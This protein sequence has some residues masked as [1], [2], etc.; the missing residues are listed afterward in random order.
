MTRPGSSHRDF[1]AF[2]PFRLYPSKR[3]TERSGV[4]T[5]IGGRALDI[6]V[7]LVE[8][9]GQIVSNKDLLREV[10]PTTTVG[11]ANLRMQMSAL[12]RALGSD[13]ARY[14]SNV[15]GRGYC[16]VAP[17]SWSPRTIGRLSRLLSKRGGYRCRLALIGWSA[18]TK[19][20]G[21]S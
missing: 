17:V 5:R 19:L 15:P 21:R 10:W 18:A 1:A 8:R 6:L 11:E 12:R 14:I 7:A 4:A 20:W 13:A 3:L 9:P 16:L 2:G